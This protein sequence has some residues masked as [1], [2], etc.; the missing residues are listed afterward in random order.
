MIFIVLCLV[1]LFLNISLEDT[2]MEKDIYIR[3]RALLTPEEEKIYNATLL[4]HSESVY[5]LGRDRETKGDW[6]GVYGSYAH[7]L[8][9]PPVKAVT[10]PIGNYTVPSGSCTLQDLGWADFQVRGLPYY[11]QNPPYWD[12]Y[13]TLNPPVTYRIDGT[14]YLSKTDQIQYPAFEWAQDEYSIDDRRIPESPL[15]FQKRLATS[16]VDGSDRG[17]P[18][19]GYF[20]I[21]L[22]FPKGAYLLSLYAYDHERV[23]STEQIVVSDLTQVL[24]STIIEEEFHEGVYL[25]FAIFSTSN[26]VVQV[27]RGSSSVNAILSGVF[28]DRLP[29]PDISTIP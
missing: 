24:N 10:V 25:K 14:K 13:K 26:I 16:W 27:I 15:L 3:K 2:E 7:I 8:P 23:R 19:N 21:T 20:N 5:Y 29:F 28:I 22:V 17:F 9:N 1:I 6:I 11:K 18:S 4:S 12:E